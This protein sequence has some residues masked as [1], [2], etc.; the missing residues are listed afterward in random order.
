MLVFFAGLVAENPPAERDRHPI[1]TPMGSHLIRRC[2][3]PGISEWNAYVQDQ[4]SYLYDDV[5][6]T[7]DHF[8][9]RRQI[10][11][12]SAK[13]ALAPEAEAEGLATVVIR[14]REPPGWPEVPVLVQ[15]ARREEAAKK[16]EEEE[17][18][19]EEAK[20]EEAKEEEAKEEEAKEEEAKEE[21]AK[22]EEAKEE[23][24]KEEE[25]KEE[26]A[27]EEEAT[28]ETPR[29]L[30]LEDPPP[31]REGCF[32]ELGGASGH[33]DHLGRRAAPER[34]PEAYVLASLPA[35]RVAGFCR[36]KP[37]LALEGRVEVRCEKTGLRATVDF[38]RADAEVFPELY[39]NA[40]AGGVFVS[41]SVFREGSSGDDECS[42]SIVR[43][44]LCAGDGVLR[45]RAPKKRASS[46]DAPSDP[47]PPSSSFPAAAASTLNPSPPLHPPLRFANTRVANV[48]AAFSRP[49][50]MRAFRFW[51]AVSDAIADADLGEPLETAKRRWIDDEIRGRDG[52]HRRERETYYAGRGK[53]GTRG[54]MRYE[55]AE[56]LA[57]EPPED[58]EPPLPRFWPGSKRRAEE[59]RQ[60]E[61]A[62]REREQEQERSRREQEQ[63]QESG[64]RSE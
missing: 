45:L 41:G 56:M 32:L 48:A 63:E 16:A 54:R 27:K 9:E 25:A 3:V 43:L 61:R 57:D 44:F 31:L 1:A 14:L 38:I 49:G 60:E 29:L 51:R 58:E 11:R 12:A 2:A 33:P 24:A 52:G 40:A 23:E 55:H 34:T 50:S 10:V 35:I 13:M 19:K 17:A 53:G 4:C 5:V 22:E 47:S 6:R 62:R 18:K 30:P 26:E 59:R 15:K 8:I 39:E 37:T 21:E 42:E 7:V 36:G 20:E 64:E 28:I 46:S